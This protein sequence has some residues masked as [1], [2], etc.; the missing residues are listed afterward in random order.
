MCGGSFRIIG[1]F[2]GSSIS[3]ISL[4]TV[5]GLLSSLI[6]MIRGKP[7]GGKPRE[8]ARC[9][10]LLVLGAEPPEPCSSVNIRYGL[11]AIVTGKGTCAVAPSFQNKVLIVLI[12]GLL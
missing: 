10:P 5:V 3:S 1:Q 9:C 6:S 11:P 2:A 7:L 4:A 8:H 12:C